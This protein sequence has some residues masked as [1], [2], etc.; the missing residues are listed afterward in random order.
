MLGGGGVELDGADAKGGQVNFAGFERGTAV[1]CAEATVGFLLVDE[2]VD[3]DIGVGGRRTFFCGHAEQDVGGNEFGGDEFVG[4]VDVA[5]EADVA[6]HGFDALGFKGVDEWKAFLKAFFFQH[7]GEGVVVA[8]GAVE[9]GPGGEFVAACLEEG[10][11]FADGEADVGGGGRRGVGGVGRCRVG[12]V[13]RCGVGEVGARCE[14]T[15]GECC[16][17][18]Q[19]G[20]EEYSGKYFATHIGLF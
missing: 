10:E 18:H 20:G 8:G 11:A 16:E 17:G 2:E 7:R 3:G 15:D 13:G 1:F 12:E 9:F 19:Q 4:L 6:E 5:G 14:P